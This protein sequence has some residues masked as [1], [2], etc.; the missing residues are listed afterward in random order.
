MRPTRPAPAPSAPHA[1]HRL[2]WLAWLAWLVV[3]ILGLAAAPSSALSQLDFE[4]LAVFDD[5]SLADLGPFSFGPSAV[6]DE[7]TLG[8]LVGFDVPGDVPAG[9]LATS[10]QQGVVNLFSPALTIDLASPVNGV[11]LSLVA[12][13]GQ[14]LLI[15]ALGAGGGVLASLDVLPPLGASGF[16]SDRFQ[17]DA[18]GIEALRIQAGGESTSFF[19]DDIEIV[20]EP[21][22]ALLLAVAGIGLA[23]LRGASPRRA[24]AV[25][26]LLGAGLWLGCVPDSVTITSPV[27][28][29]V[30]FEPTVQVEVAFLPPLRPGERVEATWV[31]GI[32]SV[33]DP[34]VIEDASADLAVDILGQSGVLPISGV[35]PGRN[36]VS[37]KRFPAGGG[38]ATAFDTVTLDRGGF[39]PDTDGPFENAGVIQDQ[40]TLASQ[41]DGSDR[42]I[43]LVVWYPSDE[44]GLPGFPL[45]G[46]VDA[47]VADGVA[48]LPVLLFSHGSC[49]IPA[50]TPFLTASLA[51]AGWIVV[52]MSHP[53]NVF[54]A[55]CAEIANLTI[56]FVERPADVSG[57]LDWLLDRNVDP[58]SPLFGLVDPQRVGVSGHSFG[59]MT[60]LRVPPLDPRFRATLP[61][62]PE[63]DS[64]ATL[65]PLPLSVPIMIQGGEIDTVTPFAT[66]QIPVFDLSER[67]RFLVELLGTGHAAFSNFCF[68]PEL[69]P[70]GLVRQYAYGFLGRYVAADRR[71]AS[72]IAPAPGVVLTADP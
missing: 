26:L 21:A 50:Q 65:I 60:A 43:D 39:F 63:Y 18:A 38:P 19:L 2:V 40:L 48:S 29:V 13:R 35:A 33:D 61:L 68:A 11:A 5:P 71:W 8:T 28:G 42:T 70:E 54:S 31:R 15:E 52:A 27:D 37:I 3:P 67:P 22:P 20:P 55:D 69:C 58:S 1:P 16:P 44:P 30:L 9:S 25:A 46:L 59:G 4:A 6:V 24:R 45:F 34:L 62:A 66:D 64:V 14:A 23:G 41:L 36:S 57:S 32:D 7:A 12:L 49:G 53:P 10:G 47:P 72:L 51:R 17:L 56:S